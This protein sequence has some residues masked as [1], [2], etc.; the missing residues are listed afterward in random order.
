ML[1]PDLGRLPEREHLE[2]Q[3]LV[4]LGTLARARLRAGAASEQRSH[5]VHVVEHGLAAH[6]G[7]VGGDHG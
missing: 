1:E 7:R 2:A 4:D 3:L 6:L 5:G